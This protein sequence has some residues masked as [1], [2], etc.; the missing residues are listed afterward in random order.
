MEAST[1]GALWIFSIIA[2]A[3]F[4]AHMRNA[5]RVSRLEKIIVDFQL[6]LSASRIQLESIKVQGELTHKKNGSTPKSEKKLPTQPHFG[7]D[8]L[9]DSGMIARPGS[10]ESKI[11]ARTKDANA[12][13]VDTWTKE[14]SWSGAELQ[15]LIDLYDRGFSVRSMAEAMRVDSKDVVHA[16]A[17]E[18]FS[19]SG[20]LENFSLAPND[21]TN[22]TTVQRNRV[23]TLI[24]SGKSIQHIAK[25]YGR[26][27]IAIVWQAIDHGFKRR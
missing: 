18:I 1:S 26:T 7:V 8:L 4:A 13:V 24:R 17:R 5:N 19:C 21:G 11:L 27:Q 2:T 14:K 23:G 12:D 16:I 3:L 22:W 20:N 25:E 6:E 9:S 15:Q 10:V